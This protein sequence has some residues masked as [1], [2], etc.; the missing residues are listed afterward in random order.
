MLDQLFSAIVWCP[1]SWRALY[2]SLLLVE[3]HPYYYYSTNPQPTHRLRKTRLIFILMFLRVVV[4]P[5]FGAYR[6]PWSYSTRMHLVATGTGIIR[7]LEINVSYYITAL[8]Y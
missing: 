6:R 2:V 4:N 1:V 8:L 3:L 7:R 5:I